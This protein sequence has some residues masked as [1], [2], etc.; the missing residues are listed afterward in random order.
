M[1]D[2]ARSCVSR[3][4]LRG[5]LAK[6]SLRERIGAVAKV[7]KSRLV[8]TKRQNDQIGLN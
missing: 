5:V 2:Y 8:E 4:F 1:F 6:V 7:N 3:H